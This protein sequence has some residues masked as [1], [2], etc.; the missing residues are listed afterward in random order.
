MSF[1]ISLRQIGW[2][3]AVTPLLYMRNQSLREPMQTA[4]GH[5]GSDS[6]G[7]STVSVL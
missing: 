7:A 4:Q 3:K 6:G 1:N 2:I 5:A